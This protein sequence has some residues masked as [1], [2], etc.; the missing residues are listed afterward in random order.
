MQR[1]SKRVS[2]SKKLIEDATILDS[3]REEEVQQLKQRLKELEK[4]IS[5]STKSASASK[6]EDEVVITSTST[7]A[8]AKDSDESVMTDTCYQP[9]YQHRFA[10]TL[11]HKFRLPEKFDGNSD[12]EIFLSQVR[13]YLSMAN[14][15]P[16]QHLYVF[17]NL[18]W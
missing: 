13:L 14:I 18:S 3:S 11:I 5:Q 7:G 1:Q 4:V 10:S 2:K 12:V 16:E 15:H 17:G 8:A 6:D 9:Q